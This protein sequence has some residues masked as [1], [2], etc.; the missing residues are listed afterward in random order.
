MVLKL[1]LMPLWLLKPHESIDLKILDNLIKSI[2]TNG[3]LKK[4]IVVDQSAH[5]ILDGHHRVR[6]LE[7]IGCSRVPR[8]LVDY[9]SPQIVVFS[10]G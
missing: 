8:L 3:L 5:I 10:R 4:A 1:R 2:E 7:L 9:P 6:A